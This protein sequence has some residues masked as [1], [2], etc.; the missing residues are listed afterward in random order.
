MVAIS[1]ARDDRTSPPAGIDVTPEEAAAML[2]A[3]LESSGSRGRFI[4]QLS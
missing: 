3:V 1:A 2:R 4:R